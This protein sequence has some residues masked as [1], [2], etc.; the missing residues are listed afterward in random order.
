MK[1]SER[2]IRA[3]LFQVRLTILLTQPQANKLKTLADGRSLGAVIR[4]MIDGYSSI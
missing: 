3:T 2:K 1:Q 4:K